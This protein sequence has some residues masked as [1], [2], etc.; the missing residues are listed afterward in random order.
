MMRWV[1][2]E[3]SE[4]ERLRQVGQYLEGARAH[5]AVK[6]FGKALE[7]LDRARELDAF[8]VEIEA[9]TRL[10]RSS[11][12]KG[13]RRKLLVRRVAETEETLGK[14]KLDLALACVDQTLANSGRRS[15]S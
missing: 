3:L 5:L 2:Q 1:I 7:A 9:L 15:G 8:N 10:V 11:E 12:E 14:G 6:N 4:Q 13:E